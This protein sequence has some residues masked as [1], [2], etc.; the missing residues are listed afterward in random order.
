MLLG[1]LFV[2]V[3]NVSRNTSRRMQ[4]GVQEANSA[5]GE[6]ADLPVNSQKVDPHPV[7]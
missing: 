4:P 2:I 1:I 6:G 5:L 3:K 7:S